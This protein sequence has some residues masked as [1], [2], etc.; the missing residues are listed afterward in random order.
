MFGPSI[1]TIWW[2]LFDDRKPGAGGKLLI[3]CSPQRAVWK[4]SPRI[5]LQPAFN[6]TVEVGLTM[7]GPAPT[8]GT[9][10]QTTVNFRFVPSRQ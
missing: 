5:E 4:V 10:N 9:W 3:P 2:F 7:P 8:I 1:T 6:M